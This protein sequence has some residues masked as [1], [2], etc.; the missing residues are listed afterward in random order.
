MISL[1]KLSSKATGQKALEPLKCLTV[2]I[3]GFIS[4]DALA[5]L[6]VFKGGTPSYPC[7]NTGRKAL[8]NGHLELQENGQQTLF[9]GPRARRS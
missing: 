6:L 3:M 9:S 8:M 1:T 2:T 5:S 4:N 7:T